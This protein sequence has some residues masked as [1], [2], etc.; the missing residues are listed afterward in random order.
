[1]TGSKHG[2]RFNHDQSAAGYDRDVLN[3]EDPIRNGY[4]AVLSWVVEHAAVRTTE[5]A[6][7]LGIGSGN[8]AARLPV[9]PGPG[10]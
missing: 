8:L 4:D 3:E 6:V 10:G 9:C 2:Q 7:D 1:M 5:W